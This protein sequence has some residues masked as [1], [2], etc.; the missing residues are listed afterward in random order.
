MRRVL[1]S[2]AEP[3]GDVLGAELVNALKSL[4]PASFFGLAG[5]RMRAA[6]VEPIADMEDVSAMGIVEVL[7]RLPKILETKSRLRSA[8]ADQPAAAIFIDA[9]DLHHPLGRFARKRGVPSIGYVSPQVWAWRG[10]RARTMHEIFDQLLCLFAFE[11]PL[12]PGTCATWVGHPVVDRLPSREEVNPMLFGIA[13]GSRSQEIAR[14]KEPF[15][16]VVDRVRA[17]IPDAHFHLLCPA[18]PGPLPDAVSHVTDVRSLSTARGVLTKSGTITLELAVMGV[19]Q[20]V[21][22]RVN[23]LT[24]G[25]GRMLIQ[26]IDHIAMPNILARKQ[27]VP[28]Y[29]Q[30][31]DPEVLAQALL[32][33]PSAQSVDLRALGPSGASER[34]AAQVWTAMEA[35]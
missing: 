2:A 35:S 12:F 10:D 5:P 25:L 19:P 32:D 20:V 17:Q 6:G 4:G 28:E 7:G 8:I 16:A 30:V 14:M 34:A 13:P 27:V 21:A 33:L 9:P 31:L 29:I 26:G 23:P 18:D 24:H 3:S 15:L 11:P 1:V 22:H